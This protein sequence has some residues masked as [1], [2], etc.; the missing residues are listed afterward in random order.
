MSGASTIQVG[1][2][3][4][5]D[6]V[7]QAGTSSNYIND[8]DPVLVPASN[9]GRYSIVAL[10][11]TVEGPIRITT[12]GGWFE[13]PR[14]PFLPQ[15]SSTFTGI[16]SVA[17]EGTPADPSVPSANAG[18]LIALLG[19]GLNYGPRYVTF[20][21]VDETGTVGTITRD[22]YA[23]EEQGDPLVLD[24][25]IEVPLLARTGLVH[26]VG[27]DAAFPLQIVPT[28]QG[29]TPLVAGQRAVLEGTGLPEGDLTIRI[30]GQLATDIDVQTV[31]ERYASTGNGL[32]DGQELVT[33]MVPA[34]IGAGVVTVTT[35]GGSATIRSGF[36][37][38]LLPDISPAAD[39][40][41]SRETALP[42][43]LPTGSRLTI[44]S[45]LDPTVD[46]RPGMSSPTP[47]STL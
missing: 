27:A 8:L 16:Q 13:V 6:R 29:V 44:E 5:S 15:V 28:I 10:G 25:A 47:T 22:G 18:Q 34:G 35:S 45:S 42:I 11:L 36:A 32:V 41:D 4:M 38:T 31:T 17:E 3:V 20:D 30:D 1:G 39:V 24:L 19:T 40:G 9:N 33:F 37:V 2:I 26:I 14:F 7:T 21:A 43:D 23:V 12:A 46:P